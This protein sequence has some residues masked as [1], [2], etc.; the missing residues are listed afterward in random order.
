MEPDG[1]SPCPEPPAIDPCLEPDESCHT[2]P[3]RF[4]YVPGGLLSLGF[5]IK[6]LYALLLHESD[7]PSLI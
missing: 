1:F 7:M 5:P 3:H 6:I 2:L 4:L